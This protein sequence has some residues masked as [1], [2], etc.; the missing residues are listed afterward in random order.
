MDIDE[1]VDTSH[2]PSFCKVCKI[3][4]LETVPESQCKGCD[5]LLG[6][7]VKFELTRDME[8]PDSSH[9]MLVPTLPGLLVPSSSV[10]QTQ[11]NKEP[12]QCSLCRQWFHNRDANIIL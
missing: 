12:V 1:H 4:F 9:E 11:H 3:C 10:Q 8:E 6:A 7:E 2:G 5:Q